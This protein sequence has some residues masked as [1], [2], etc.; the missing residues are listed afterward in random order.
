MIV[1]TAVVFFMLLFPNRS[2]GWG[3]TWLGI[4]LEQ[5][6]NSA[7]GKMGPFRYN[8]TFQINRAGYDSD[9]Y[10]GFTPN[11]VP[12]YTFSAGP[13][14]SLYLPLR[15]G[16]VFDI[17]ENP[18][19]VFYLNTEK[20]RALNNTFRGRLHLALDRLYFQASGGLIDAKQRVTSEVDINVRYKA[21]DLSGLAFWQISKGSAAALQYSQSTLE[22]ENPDQGEINW[23]LLNRQENRINLAAFLQ[24]PTRTRFFLAAAYGSYV[25]KETTSSFKDSRSFGFFGGIEFLPPPADSGQTRG[26]QGSL[27]LGYKY[28]DVLDPERKDY[29]GLVG[30]TSV[31]IN[32]I[33]F[34]TFRGVFIR[35]VQF[36]VFSDVGYYIQ[37]VYGGGISR[38]LTK[39]INFSY[40]LSFGRNDYV[41]G[42][43]GGIERTAIMYL[44]HNFM[45]SF[46]LRENLAFNLTASLGERTSDFIEQ[47]NRRFFIG[48]SLT[49]GY[50]SGSISMGGSSFSL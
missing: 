24:G 27:N 46:Q 6:I 23:G 50:S 28:F 48:F 22:Y 8:A 4:G 9:I 37:T 42:E 2:F 41:G 44:T 49:Y 43:D 19:Y 7:R 35:D 31:A 45:L 13:S 32:L 17:T 33:K 14:L 16:I 12:D 3:S 11:P 5:I 39:R 38:A 40:D 10:F 26:I 25:F 30:N 15:K 34:T 21:N 1:G 29:E 20:D 18:Q 47:T 36:S